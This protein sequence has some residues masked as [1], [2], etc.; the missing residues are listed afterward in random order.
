MIAF[1]KGQLRDIRADQAIVEV[2]GLGYEIYVHQ[3][4]LSRLPL[5]GQTILL[6]TH[7]A[8]SE[9][10]FKLYG[11][12]DQTELEL[13][14]MLLSISGI[15]AK[16]ALNVLGAMAPAQFYKAVA[17]QDEK[18]LLRI[19]GVGK[20][21]AQR[22]VFELKDKVAAELALT[23]PDSE[24]SLPFNEVIEALEAL[25]YSRSEVFSELLDLNNQGQMGQNVA[26]NVKLVL[27]KKAQRLKK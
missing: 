10:E 20:K 9:N 19:P 3:R 21:M 8:V 16:A 5:L 23:P 22:L 18:A 11:F 14:R 25:G 6:H 27:K 26:E 1:I 15:G 7:L 13:F 24:R 12:L 2:N 4:A 17:S